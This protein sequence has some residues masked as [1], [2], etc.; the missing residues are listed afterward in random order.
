MVPGEHV[1]NAYGQLPGG[2]A[3][4]WQHE[5]IDAMAAAAARRPE[6][7]RPPMTLDEIRE[8]VEHVL[9]GKANEK[10]DNRLPRR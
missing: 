2:Y 3:A 6:P 9:K 5:A 8:S 4:D 1:K 10:T 7:V